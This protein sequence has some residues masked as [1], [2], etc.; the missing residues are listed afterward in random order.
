MIENDDVVVET[1]RLV[2]V[3]TEAMDEAGRFLES[4]DEPERAD[5]GCTQKCRLLYE[6]EDRLRKLLTESLW[7]VKRKWNDIAVNPI[8][9][10]DLKVY[11]TCCRE[12]KQPAF[13]FDARVRRFSRRADSLFG[14]TDIG[15]W[16]LSDIV[17]WEKEAKAIIELVDGPR[18][19]DERLVDVFKI[20]IRR[21]KP[22]FEN[23]TARDLGR[24]VMNGVSL[25]N[26]PLWISDKR[27]AIVMGKMLGKTCKEMNASFRFETLEGKPT[28]LSYSGHGPVLEFSQY[29]IYDIIRE[30]LEAVKR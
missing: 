27:Q 16:Y 13:E 15:R 24:F 29:E 19:F 23:V 12:F 2:G 28:Q 9:M 26:R 8:L 18:M 21:L 17:G 14:T 11:L 1:K 6:N 20:A 10:E 5:L 22:F 4:K 7:T 3:I 30:M 25:K